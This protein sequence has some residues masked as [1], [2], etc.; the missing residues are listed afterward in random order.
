MEESRKRKKEGRGGRPQEV[1]F[2]LFV[3]PTTNLK[4]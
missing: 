3:G 4:Q 1:K 2:K